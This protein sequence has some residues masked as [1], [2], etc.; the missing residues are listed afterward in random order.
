MSDESF[1][2]LVRGAYVQTFPPAIELISEGDSADFL[3]IVLDGMVE[4]FASWNRRETTMA[5][6]GPLATFILAATIRDAPYLMSARTLEKTRIVLL[7]S[8]DVRTVFATDNAF[9]RSV[10]AELATCYRTVVKNSK[11][12]RLRNSI[13]RL[14]N[15]I[16]R[17]LD[18]ADG[19]KGFVLPIEKRR[20]AAYLGMTP[21]NLSRAIRT[22]GQ[23]G[24]EVD[25][26]RVTI[27]DRA[28]LERLAKPTPLI[29]DP[30]H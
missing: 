18:T 10:V 5:T 23:Y 7:P 4:L 25:G 9:A 21:E 16:L 3:H 1:G 2:R 8:E 27:T 15:Y 11:D 12:L 6:L 28:D 13:E 24:V 19:G 22:L 29:D 14:A 26:N 30:G 17:H 20:L